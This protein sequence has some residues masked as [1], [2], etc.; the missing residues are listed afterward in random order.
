RAGPWQS[1]VRPDGRVYRR[2]DF[3]LRE[4]WNEH[5]RAAHFAGFAAP[6]PTSSAPSQGISPIVVVAWIAL[7][8]VLLTIVIALA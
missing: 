1:V 2:T 5:T 3:A 4:P 6:A 7:F 8:I